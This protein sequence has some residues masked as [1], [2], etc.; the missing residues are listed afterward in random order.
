MRQWIKELVGISCAKAGALQEGLNTA[1]GQAELQ[2]DKALPEIIGNILN[3]ALGFVGVLF[4]V[5]IIYGGVLW[6]TAGGS[7]TLQVGAKSKVQKA[8]TIIINGI[9][10]LILVLASYAILKYIFSQIQPGGIT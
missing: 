1:A 6:M 3:Y 10:G 5:M 4:L 7:I 2:T 8:R 9:I